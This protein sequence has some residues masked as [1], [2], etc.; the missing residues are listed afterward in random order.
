MANFKNRN[1]ALTFGS[2][3][4]SFLR[5]KPKDC[6][7]YSEDGSQFKIHKEILGQSAFLRKILN[8]AKD[9]CCVA[10]DIFFPCSHK[11]LG[12]IVKFL[13]TGKIVSDDVDDLSKT[14]ENLKEILGFP[15]ELPF[16]PEDRI[17]PNDTL[18]YLILNHNVANL[19]VKEQPFDQLESSFQDEN[20]NDTNVQKPEIDLQKKYSTCCNEKDPLEDTTTTTELPNEMPL[21]PED[22]NLESDS[23][24]N[25]GI[26]AF[27]AKEK[28]FVQEK[29]ISIDQGE[30]EI[31]FDSHES[32]NELT[33]CYN[34]NDMLGNAATKG[35]DFLTESNFEGG[36]DKIETIGQTD[37]EKNSKEEK[38][39]RNSS[40]INVM[41]LSWA[42]KP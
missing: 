14:I 11:E 41:H 6:C 3:I 27:T 33:K 13:Y 30:N 29:Y 36:S 8:S 37:A 25:H 34:E 15:N 22:Q 35:V 9:S 5:A 21:L 31:G 16:W 39:K 7:L 42:S 10:V 1:H 26:P 4:K 18:L 2:S 40:V 24:S 20:D 17:I 38:F 23:S 12:L 19:S 32:E 28:P